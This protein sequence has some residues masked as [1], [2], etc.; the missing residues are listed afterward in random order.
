MRIRVTGASGFLG[1]PL[2][3]ALGRLGTVSSL[4]GEVS[5]PATFASAGTVDAVV[6]LAAQSN[7]PRSAQDPVGTWRTNVDGTLQV[8]E[9]AR[10]DRVGRV[11]LVS[12][13]HVYGRPLRSPIDEEHP[14]HPRSPYGASKMAAE[15]LAAGYHASYGLDVVVVRPFNVYGPGQ[16]PGFLV[17]DIL[18]PLRDGRAPVLGDPRP[19]RDYTFLDDA[20]AFLV[21]AATAPA[22]LAGE[23]LNLGS[24]RGVSVA[25]L[26]TQAAA[27][28][29]TGLA[30]AFEPARARA[31]EGGA[32]VAD[33]RKAKRLLGWEP[34]VGLDEGLRRTWQ[35]WV[36][37]APPHR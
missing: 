33:V 14:L 20:V 30:P 18:N 32:V 17:P 4:D 36:A 24:G 29:G 9:W 16:A 3:R 21:K 37:A 27:A 6:H 35:A 19:I 1:Q 8:L 15:A 22:V 11:V 25:E 26:A 13:A 31:N 5:D 34:R 23:A 10:R 2:M 12:S 28:S 7:V